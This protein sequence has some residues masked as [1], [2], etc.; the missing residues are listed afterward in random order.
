MTSRASR[1][2][3]D[4]LRSTPLETRL[5]DLVEQQAALRELAIAVAEM[6]APEVIYE[7]VAKQAADVAG[8]DAG[9]VVRFRVDGV[10]EVVGSWRM[11]SRHTGSVIPLDGA[12][13]VA[14]VARTG[15]AARMSAA[16]ELSARRPGGSVPPASVTL[17][18]GVAVPIR[19]G[20]ELWG[21][22]LVV[23]RTEERIPPDLE[24]RLSTFADLVGLAITNTDTSARLLSQATSDPL[25]GLLNHRAFQERVESEVG[26]AQ[27]YGRPL[28][29]VLLDLDFFKSINDAYG[30][31]AGDTALMH[32]G[33]LLERC[34][35][36]GDVLG[37][38]GGDEFALLLPETNAE[39]ALP[40]AER[41]AAEFREAPVGVASHLTMSAGVSD[42]THA[43]GSRELFRLADGALYA[44]K[45]H[46]RDT[47]VLY[48]PEAVHEFS[49]S[50]RVDRMERMQSLAALRSLARSVDSRDSPDGEHSERVGVMVRRLAEASGWAPAQVALL[51]EAAEIHDVGK[52]CVPQEVLRKPAALTLAEYELVKA[53][54]A[55]GAEMARD[56]LNEEQAVW[57]AQ[58]HERFDGTGY[59]NRLANGE[60]AA[61]SDLLALADSWDAMT[62]ERFYNEPK[63]KREALAECLSL[64]G[65]QFSPTACDALAAIS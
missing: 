28:T 49:D 25:T 57:I 40:I 16:E 44:A 20:R 34:A 35:R 52:I 30:H 58:H 13:G 51:G 33:S 2:A 17:P 9:A 41:W 10:G 63:P 12:A 5:R 48:S 14:V 8:V 38:I 60:I 7:L 39:Q 19:V 56:A 6:R 23:A 36:A 46:G 26:R 54:A 31:Q 45:S 62:T 32:A 64:S 37:R 50:D 29:L 55:V 21:S 65:S 27:R 59:P 22:L 11:G 43:N 18:G 47:V 42:L 1:A 4:R 53:H 15:R 3:T 61:G 24:E